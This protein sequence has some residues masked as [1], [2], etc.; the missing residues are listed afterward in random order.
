MKQYCVLPH[1]Q[2]YFVAD[3]LVDSQN[4]YNPNR[5]VYVSSYEELTRFFSGLPSRKI[6]VHLHD[7]ISSDLESAICDAH[8]KTTIHRVAS[9]RHPDSKQ[10]EL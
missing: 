3:G 6:M 7:S 4:V 2:G 5:R 9:F 10:V 1:N 8:T